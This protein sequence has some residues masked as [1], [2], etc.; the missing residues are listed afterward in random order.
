MRE[1][2]EFYNNLDV[3]IKKFDIN[4]IQDKSLT[5]VKNMFDISL[6]IL[7]NVGVVTIS[8][9]RRYNNKPTKIKV[10]GIKQFSNGETNLDIYDTYITNYQ[11]YNM[12][13]SLANEK[14]SISN[15]VLSE[16]HT[17]IYYILQS[18][19][20]IST[21]INDLFFSIKR[22]DINLNSIHDKIRNNDKIVGKTV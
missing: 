21:N 6:E 10:L 12:Y 18:I 4:G 8:C 3:Y 20:D 7:D 15:I 16:I 11:N 17:I 9:Y 14:L 2:Y 19:Y 1:L 13:N 22:G 5:H